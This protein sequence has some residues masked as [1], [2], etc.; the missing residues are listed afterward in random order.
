MRPARLMMSRCRGRSGT[1]RAKASDSLSNTDARG[2]RD[3]SFGCECHWGTAAFTDH[4]A[5]RSA[6]WC[7]PIRRCPALYADTDVG[8]RFSRSESLQL[9]W[10]IIWAMLQLAEGLPLGGHPSRV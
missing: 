3:I 8:C 1:R 5:R 4:L 2:S 10:L 6:G 7:G 9:G